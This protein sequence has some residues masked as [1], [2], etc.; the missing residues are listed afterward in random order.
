MTR[1]K[2]VLKQGKKRSPPKNPIHSIQFDLFSSFLTNDRADVSN[3]VDVW[4]SI[5]KYF[6]TSHQTK[7]LRTESGLAPRFEWRYVHNGI[8]CEVIIQPA[9]IKQGNKDIAYYP[10]VTEE[11]IEE[12][13]KKIMVDQNYSIHD[14][15]NTE[16][17]VAFTLGLLQ[18]ELKNRG[19]S[20][21]ISQIKHAITVMS[22]CVITLIK[23]GREVWT[24]AI[25]Q[26][27]V[28]IGRDQ[29]LDDTSAQH[30][31]RMPVF[32]AHAINH[33]EYRQFNYQRLM[34]CSE[35]LTRWLY[36]QLIHRYRQASRVNYYHVMYSTIERNSGLLRQGRAD[37]N[38]RKVIAA[39][40]EL[41]KR[42]VLNDYYVDKRKQSR[43]IVDVKYTLHPAQP[44]IAEQ[45]AANKR[46]TDSV[47]LLH[48]SAR[49]P[50]VPA[51]E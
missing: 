5:P 3:T 28:T 26:D 16:T 35:Q 40:D 10:S 44:F 12:A 30:I 31:A 13:L 25:L 49:R 1:S 15:N 29:Y 39:L 32:I 19:R 51:A 37:D 22:R 38:R 27:L 47:V 20:R 36:K 11:L 24:G 8:D 33:L 50:G 17:W 45:K 4:E 2:N 7:I 6:I 14:P 41:K 34:R 42:E 46:Q 48:Q 43:K 21:S 23:E 18:K 9:L